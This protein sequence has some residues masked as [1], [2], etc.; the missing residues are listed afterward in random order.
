[1]PKKT[2]RTG[3]AGHP[4]TDEETEAQRKE[5]ICPGSQVKLPNIRTRNQIPVQGDF[6]VLSLGHQ[7]A[8]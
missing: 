4:Y 3:G 1:M 8:Q 2:P 7:Q 6:S 5:R